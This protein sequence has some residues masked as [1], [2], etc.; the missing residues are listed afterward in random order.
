M[1]KAKDFSGKIRL[2]EKG[3]GFVKS[4][5]GDIFVR[6]ALVAKHGVKDGDTIFLKAVPSSVK[7]G[8]LEAVS[9][10]KA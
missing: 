4:T 10:T 8:S 3:F 1:D 5:S 6:P 9:I 2:H 7:A